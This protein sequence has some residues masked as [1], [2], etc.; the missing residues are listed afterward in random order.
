MWW[1]NIFYRSKD[2]IKYFIR[3]KH[4][5]AFV[6]IIGKHFTYGCN[7]GM[8][9]GMIHSSAKGT[10]TIGDWCSI[11]RNVTITG[12]THDPRK[13]TGEDNQIRELPVKIGN[14]VWIG[15]N[16]FIAPGVTIGDYSVIGAN[17]VVR[18]NIPSRGYIRV[19]CE[20]LTR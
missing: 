4:P 14:Y 20:T 5:F 15:D 7:T 8:M 1:L 11:G 2:Y 6:F 9:S 18:K 10:V 16:V 3:K 12:V 19:V 13:P 17:A